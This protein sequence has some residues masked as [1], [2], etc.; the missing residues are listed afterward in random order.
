MRRRLW[1][2][3][4]VPLA[5]AGCE[6]TEVTVAE[7]QD[8]VIAEVILVAGPG[9]Q[10]AMLHRT[11]GTGADNRVPGASVEVRDA[12]G[13]T[14]QFQ[15]APVSDCIDVPPDSAATVG[16][17]YASPVEAPLDIAAGGTYE[18]R[19]VLQ[20]GGV[21][22]G[23]TTLPGTFAL[24]SPAV[25][26]CAIPADTTIE[27]RWTQAADAWAYIAESSITGIRAALA[28]RGVE[29]RKDPL[30]LFGLAVSRADTSIV[31]PG[32][33][34]LFD[35]ADTDVAAALLALRRGLPPGV[36]ARIVIAATERNYVNWARGGQFNPSGIVR[37]PSVRGAGSG[38]FGGIVAH[39]I[40]LSTRP[41]SGL[42]ACL[43]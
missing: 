24:T 14:L 12:R 16:S 13:R 3:L 42:P 22:T 2:A 32:E 23:T 38:V 21:L 43:R 36:T 9:P 11:R 29:V 39:E 40:T 33:F 4:V 10:R 31:F 8:S 18:L 34:G 35:R 28:D 6:L 25:T 26:P 17:C 1:C 15:P 5:A 27:L 20:N 37:V 41:G 19:V 7:V 30:R